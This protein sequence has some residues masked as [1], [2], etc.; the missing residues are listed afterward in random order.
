MGGLNILIKHSVLLELTLFLKLIG[1]QCIIDFPSKDFVE[2][3]N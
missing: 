3:I 2:K 1:I